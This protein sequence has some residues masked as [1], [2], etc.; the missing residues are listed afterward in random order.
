[1]LDNGGVGR[2]YATLFILGN[3]LLSLHAPAYYRQLL[4][5]VVDDFQDQSAE[6]VVSQVVPF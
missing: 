2:K 1:M 5:G 6:G 4:L 3:T